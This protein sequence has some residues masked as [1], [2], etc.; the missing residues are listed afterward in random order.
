MRIQTLAKCSLAALGGD[1]NLVAFPTTAN[2]SSIIVN[3]Y[4]LDVSAVP[5]AVTFPR[6]TKQVA[7]VVQCAVNSGLKVQP[8]SGGHSYGNYGMKIFE[9]GNLMAKRLGTDA[10]T[11]ST[12]G[13]VSVDLRNFQNFSMDASTQIATVGSGLLLGN[14]TE[15]LYNSGQRFIPHGTCPLVGI[16]GHGTVGGAGPPSRHVGLTIDH[17]EEVEIVLANATVVRASQKHNPD[18]FFAVRGAGASYGIVTEFKFRTEPSPPQTIN[19][20]YSWNA[21]DAATRAKIFSSWQKWISNPLPR[22]LSSTLTVNPSIVLMAGAYFGSQEAFD[23]LRIPDAFPPISSTNTQLF[24]NFLALNQLWGSQIQQSGIAD[25]S[26]FYAK[27]LGFSRQTR[28][29]DRVIKQVF[30]YLA[31]ATT[32]AQFWALNFEVGLGAISDV[33]SSATANP[34]RDTLFFML[35]YARTQGKVSKTTTTFLDELNRVAKRGAPSAI[36]GEYAGY[37]DPKEDNGQARRNY[38]G[39][40]LERL[41]KIKADVDAGDVFHNQQSVLP[42]RSDG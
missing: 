12:T 10:T 42:L 18:L 15:L 16:G 31:N 7:A 22:Q 23:A 38:W 6:T 29:P 8:K 9:H 19:Y 5:A 4:N 14:I 27:S 30:N 36:Y 1:P 20:V 35:S 40:N 3:P 11:G 33:P 32:D 21:T 13:E 28:M 25:P 17:I 26:Y 39:A 2:H 34:H 41:M 24:T 37:V